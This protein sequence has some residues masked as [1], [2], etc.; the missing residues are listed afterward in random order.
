MFQDNE[1]D[2]HQPSLVCHE[3]SQILFH[4]LEREET[5]DKY[6]SLLVANEQI[7]SLG[8]FRITKNAYLISAYQ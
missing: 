8:I 1:V 4:A 7:N 2:H 5:C 6:R 3:V